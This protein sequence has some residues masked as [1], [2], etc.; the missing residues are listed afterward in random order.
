[1]F[2]S[3]LGFITGVIL[4]YFSG[5]LINSSNESLNYYT[6]LQIILI[7]FSFFLLFYRLTFKKI[8]IKGFAVYLLTLVLGFCYASLT[9]DKITSSRISSS[10]DQQIIQVTAYLCGLPRRGEYSFSADFCLLDLQSKAGFQLKGKT[11][12]ARLRWPLEMEVSEGVSI[13]NVKSRQPKSTVNF[14]GLS[15]EKNLFYERIVLTGT[16]KN[17]IDSIGIDSLGFF[18]R[19]KYEYHQLRRN[20][21]YRT[22][23]MLSGSTHKGIIHALLLGDRSK[24]SSQDALVLS[25]TGTQHLIAISGLHVGLVMFGLFC[26]LPRA[27]FSIVLVSVLGLVYVSLVGFTP[28]AQRA[29]IMCVCGLFYLSGYIKQSKWLIFTFTLFLILVLDPLATFNLGFWYSFL[30]VAII[31]LISQFTSFDPKH[32]FSLV[33]LQLLLIIAMVPVSSLLGTKHGLENILANLLAIPWISLLVLPLSLFWFMVSFLSKELSFIPLS[34]LDKSIELL[35]AY[36]SSLKMFNIPFAIDVH[37]IAIVC[38]VIVFLALLVFSKVNSILGLSSLAMALVIVFPSRLYNDKPELMVFDVGQG[39]SLAMKAKGRIW[40]YDT[41]P[42]FDKSSSMRNIILPYLR[43]H[44]K[45]NE[46]KGVIISHGDSDH[47]GDLLSLYDEFRPEL[48]WSGQPERLEVKSFEACR[49]GMKWQEGGLQIEVLYPFSG[50]D[51]SKLSSNNHSCVVRIS[52]R[53]KIFLLMGDLEAQAEMNLVKRYRDELKSDIL[54][55]GHHG[56]AKSS[57][58]ALLKHVQ[59]SYIVFSAGYL[60]KFGHP[61][62]VVLKRVSGFDLEHLNTIESGAIRFSE[63]FFVSSDLIEI[64]R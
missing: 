31:F 7:S 46:L 12:K 53:Q 50:L 16:V 2:K 13:F 11:Y 41:G 9:A 51:I 47:A 22:S 33:M 6:Y 52:F 30:C 28:S 1:M 24:L 29:W 57:S 17:H 58:F 27:I 64:A 37:Y 25:N 21:S 61:S 19:L 55:A 40:L 62:D 42:A 48:G 36:L 26:L 15:F 35:T 60:N 54:I 18:E 4:L 14:I 59:P 49:A 38:F 39:L 8:Y 56:A 44:R 34:I 5:K 45:S 10:F 3:M 20:L 32:W 23:E 43:Q 63:Q